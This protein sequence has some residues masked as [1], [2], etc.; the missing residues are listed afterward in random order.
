MA[1]PK[2]SPLDALKGALED[3]EAKIQ[4]DSGQNLNDLR[5]L[6]NDYLR[7]GDEPE[8]RQLLREYDRGGQLTGRAASA[9]GSGPLIWSFLAGRTLATISPGPRRSFTA[10]ST[11]SGGMACSRG[12]I[13]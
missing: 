1:G 13:P 11:P 9:G 12:G 4:E 7:R 3:A 8:R 10:T 5:A 6:L 2:L